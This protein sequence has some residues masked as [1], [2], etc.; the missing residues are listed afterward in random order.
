[1]LEANPVRKPGMV[2][3]GRGQGRGHL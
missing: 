2:I 3:P 1:M